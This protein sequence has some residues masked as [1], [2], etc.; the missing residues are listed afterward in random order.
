M[1]KTGN[2]KILAYVVGIGVTLMSF[3]NCS[4]YSESQIDGMLSS[5]SS[6]APTS[7]QLE[8]SA[9]KIIQRKC[10][11]CHN[12]DNPSGQIDDLLTKDSLLYYRLIIP[13]EPN[14]SDLYTVIKNGDMPPAPNK[15]L[16]SAESQLIYDWILNGFSDTS[17]GITP[18]NQAPITVL[19]PTF[20][21]IKALIINNKCL[22]CHNSTNSSGGVNFST[23]ASTMNTVQ[24]GRPEVSTIYTSTVSQRMPTT[25]NKLTGAELQA[26]QQWI[27]NGAPN[28]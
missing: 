14:L 26:I 4:M 19:A 21:S 6:G 13:G 10:V 18:P 25:A 7:E 17:S 27:T 5:T 23:Y 2:I 16:T 11:S 22:S 12:A 28:N 15:P 3:Q 8:A 1:I 9:M 20:S 24:A